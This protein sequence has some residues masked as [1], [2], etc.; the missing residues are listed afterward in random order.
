MYLEILKIKSF[1]GFS[2]IVSSGVICYGTGGQLPTPKLKFN[3]FRSL[4]KTKKACIIQAARETGYFL[5]HLVSTVKSE[6]LEKRSIF[7]LR[8]GNRILMKFDI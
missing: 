2:L 6:K 5:W 4:V 8:A 7:I 3:F 1:P